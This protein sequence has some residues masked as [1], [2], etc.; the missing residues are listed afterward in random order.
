MICAN[1]Q[2]CGPTLYRWPFTDRAKLA[3]CILHTAMFIVEKE[4]HEVEPTMCHRR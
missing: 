3:L 4:E 1:S 2:H